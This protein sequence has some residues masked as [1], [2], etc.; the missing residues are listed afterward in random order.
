M[1]TI[2]AKTCCV[3]GVLLPAEVIRVRVRNAH[4]RNE[5][6]VIGRNTDGMEQPSSERRTPRPVTNRGVS[7]GQSCVRSNE[8]NVSTILAPTHDRPLVWGAVA[9][10]RQPGGSGAAYERCHPPGRLPGGQD[11]HSLTA[12]E[13]SFRPN[14][15]PHAGRQARKD[16]SEESEYAAVLGLRAAER[17]RRLGQGRRQQAAH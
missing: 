4:A 3:A 16:C 9:C 7:S 10:S 2:A 8:P 11:E 1:R 12:I 14:G 5:S 6:R 13:L 15:N 17:S